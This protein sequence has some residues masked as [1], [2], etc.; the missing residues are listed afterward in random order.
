MAQ[1]VMRLQFRLRAAFSN[2]DDDIATYR[3]I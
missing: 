3:A 1:P 2:P